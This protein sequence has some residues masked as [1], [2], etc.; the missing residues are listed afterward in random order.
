MVDVDEGVNVAEP[1]E[2]GLIL[3][4]GEI[5]IREQVRVTASG[6]TYQFDFV[7]QAAPAIPLL[8]DPP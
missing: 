7:E 2:L 3:C 5:C 1:C 8:L 4:D 6:D